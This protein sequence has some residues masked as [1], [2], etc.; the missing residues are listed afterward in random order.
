MPDAPQHILRFWRDLEIFNIPDAP[1]S[2]D[3]NG[4][5]KVSTLRDG[6]RLPWQD[7]EFAV[8][9]EYT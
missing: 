4:Q 2:K 9:D 1:S 5:T 7:K 3:N 8:T 6:D